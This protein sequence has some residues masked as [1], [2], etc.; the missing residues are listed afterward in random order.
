MKKLTELQIEELQ[1]FGYMVRSNDDISKMEK[2]IKQNIKD[3][4]L[5]TEKKPKKA[6]ASSKEAQGVMSSE[7]EDFSYLDELET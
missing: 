5:V 7:N 6:E 1:S 4:K 2:D 3:R